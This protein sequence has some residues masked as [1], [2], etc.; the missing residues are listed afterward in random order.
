MRPTNITSIGFVLMLTVITFPGNACA[1]RPTETASKKTPAAPSLFIVRQQ[2]DGEVGKVDG[3]AGVMVVN[4]PTGK[5]KIVSPLVSASPLTKGD[6][7]LVEVGL[8]PPA[9]R[10]A[11]PQKQLEPDPAILRER[12]QG[13]VAAVSP[14]RG[15]LKLQVPDGAF[16]M[17][18]PA[19]VLERFKKDDTIPVELVLLP[20]QATAR[21]ERAGLATLLLS[22]FGKK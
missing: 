15:L 6:A 13:Q 1:V 2:F 9:S 7:V 8:L 12:L 11:L 18:L 20:A 16:D 22:I 10:A 17:W 4:I 5:L 14:T 21:T 19:T 3:K